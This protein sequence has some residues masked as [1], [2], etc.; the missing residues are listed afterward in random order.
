MAIYIFEFEMEIKIYIEC[1]NK[2][3][4]NIRSNIIY[5][6]HAIMRD[7]R[8]FFHVKSRKHDKVIRHYNTGMSDKVLQ[9]AITII[10]YLIDFFT[11]HVILYKV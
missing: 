7:K 4:D 1:Y 8:N 5:V 6:F 9:I 11:F 3:P 10:I 2:E